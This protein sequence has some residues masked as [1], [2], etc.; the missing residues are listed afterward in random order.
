[1]VIAAHRREVERTVDNQ[2]GHFPRRMRTH[3]AP[4]HMAHGKID[5]ST[6]GSTGRWTVIT[7]VILI[8]TSRTF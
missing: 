6:R 8:E 2:G 7:V 3:H 4:A 1:M 5:R